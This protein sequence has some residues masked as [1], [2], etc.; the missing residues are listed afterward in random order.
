MGSGGI[1]L[2]FLT[3]ELDGG[4]WSASCL[5]RFIPGEI[6]PGAHWIGGWVGSR[7]SLN[8]MEIRGRVSKQVTYGYKT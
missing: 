3:S 2:P 8:A 5:D 7:T 1:A 6:A 4:E